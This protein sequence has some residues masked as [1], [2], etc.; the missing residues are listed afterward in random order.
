MRKQDGALFFWK[1]NSSL[2]DDEVYIKLVTDKYS[3]LLEEG[4]DLQDPRVLWDFI[5]YKIR[6]E[7]ITYSKHKARNRREKLSALE[8]KIKERTAK[9]DEY[10]SPE[11][12]NDLEIFQ[13]EYDRQY[14]YIAQGQD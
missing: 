9:C 10:P 14:E 4:K 5:K 11:N 6:Y 2:L 7:T 3:D 12:L 8:E 1:F 13:T